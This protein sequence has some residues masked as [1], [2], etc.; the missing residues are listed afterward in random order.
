MSAVGLQHLFAMPG[1][2]HYQLHLF[3]DLTVLRMHFIT[4]IFSR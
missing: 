4:L 3:S 1:L 2:S